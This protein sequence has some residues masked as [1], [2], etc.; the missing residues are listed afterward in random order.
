MYAY[1]EYQ[2]LDN[3]E[4]CFFSEERIRYQIFSTSDFSFVKKKIAL[5]PTDNFLFF[6]LNTI[7]FP[8]L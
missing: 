5:T 6:L 4:Y 8:R 3:F 1:N 2:R 7:V